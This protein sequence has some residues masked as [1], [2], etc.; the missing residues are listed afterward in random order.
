MIITETSFVGHPQ[1]IFRVPSVQPGRASGYYRWAGQINFFFHRSANDGVRPNRTNL[2]QFTRD[3]ERQYEAAREIDAKYGIIRPVPIELPS[4]TAFFEHIGFD[5]KARE[6]AN[7]EEYPMQWN[8]SKFVH[9]AR[10]P[11]W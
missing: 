4:L 1:R 7:P 11:R 3:S 6:Y 8:G 10:K 2:R 5:Y 9:P